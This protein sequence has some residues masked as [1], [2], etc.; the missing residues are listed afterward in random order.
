MQSYKVANMMRLIRG[1]AISVEILFVLTIT[2]TR[3]ITIRN[4]HG[5]KI[6]LGS[7]SRF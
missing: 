3:G 7:N 5:F 4:E 2:A 6:E 1:D